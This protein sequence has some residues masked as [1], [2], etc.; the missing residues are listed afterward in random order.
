MESNAGLIQYFYQQSYDYEQDFS[1]SNFGVF[2]CAHI[3][4]SI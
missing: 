1:G 2:L 3:R 4:N